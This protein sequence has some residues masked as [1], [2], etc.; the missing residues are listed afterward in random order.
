MKFAREIT[1]ENLEAI[2]AWNA[3]VTPD[4]EVVDND[5]LLVTGTADDDKNEIMSRAFFD[6]E[7]RFVDE[8]LPNAFSE[9]VDITQN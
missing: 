6:T 1:T 8:E 7:F 2:V 5:C 9:V 4:A 3:G